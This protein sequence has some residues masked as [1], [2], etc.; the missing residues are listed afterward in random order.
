[1]STSQPATTANQHLTEDG[2]HRRIGLF[3]ATMLVAGNMVGSGIF[4]VSADMARDVGGAGWLLVLWLITGVMTVLGGLCYAELA[5]AMPK[6]GGQYLFLKEAFSPLWGFLYGW[7]AFTV[8]QCGSIAAVAVAF[9]KFLGVLV[10]AL[11]TGGE[12]TLL[13][14]PMAIHIPLQLPWMP[15]AVTIF[16]REH[17]TISTGQLIATGVIILLT[18]INCLGVASGALVQNIFTVAKLFALGLVI[19]MGLGVALDWSVVRQNLDS[20]WTPALET[21]RVSRTVKLTDLAPTLAFVLVAGAAMVGSLFSADAWANVTLTAGEVKNPERNMPLSLVLGTCM[22]IGLY[23]LCNLAYL[24]VLPVQG[25]QALADDLKKQANV[26]P[27][28]TSKIYRGMA[29]ELGI[30]QAQDDRVGTAVMD[31]ASP[32]WG[33]VVMALGIMISTFGCVNGMILVTARLYYAMARDRLFFRVAGTLNQRGVPQASLIM[34]GVWS[35]VLVFSGTYSELLDY[36]I[37]ASL[38]FYALT[39]A[40]LMVLRRKRPDLHRPYKVPFYPVVPILYGLLCLALMF[41]LLVVRPEYTWPGLILV[42]LGIPVYYLW[43]L[44]PGRA[45]GPTV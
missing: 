2:F 13:Q 14:V 18:F 17:F 30:S 42:A 10:P 29:R 27:K 22:V 5:S 40:G 43:K 39:V 35:I 32:G 8:I 26:E 24:A 21:E 25:D 45:I 37:F 15:E 44:I 19:C 23:I 12:A 31:V 11:G 38:L 4:I 1:V 3:T 7:S 28:E 33:R 16:E 9:T 20:A 34:Q 41:I 6:A 36:V